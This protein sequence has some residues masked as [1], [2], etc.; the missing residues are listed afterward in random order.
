MGDDGGLA[1]CGINDDGMPPRGTGLE[2]GLLLVLLPV[3]SGCRW[4]GEAA[5]T[6]TA[7]E[8]WAYEPPSGMVGGCA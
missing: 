6:G 3:A 1:R 5:T 2:L 7:G 4:D 8:R